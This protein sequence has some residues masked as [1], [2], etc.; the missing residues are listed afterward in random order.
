[1]KYLKSYN[2]SLRD[3]MLPKSEEEIEDAVK[4]LSFDRLLAMISS[5]K[6]SDKYMPSDEKIENFIKDKTTEELLKMIGREEL[7]EKY[8]PPKEEISEFLKDKGLLDIM[9]LITMRYLPK[10]LEPTKQDFIDNMSNP[11]ITFKG[12]TDFGGGSGQGSIESSY[13]NLVKLFGEPMEGDDYK[14][15]MEWSAIDNNGNIVSIYDWKSTNLYDDELPDPSHLKGLESFSWN[16]GA[17]NEQDAINLIG[18]IYKN[19]K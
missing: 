19:T 1:M 6:L 9:R 14:V 3:K 18:Y 4:N 12:T 11:N 7:P 8:M 2:E 15:S 16:I 13:D 10:S 17:K 5:G